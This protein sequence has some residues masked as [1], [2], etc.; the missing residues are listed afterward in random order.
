MSLDFELYVEVDTG[1][2]EFYSIDLFQKNITHNLNKMAKEAD[3]YKWLWGL[4][5]NICAGALIKPLAEGLYKLKSDP[6]RFKK[7]EPS[8]GWGTYE[9]FYAS[10]SQIYDA[11]LKHPKALIKIYK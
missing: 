3:L 5:N 1:D 9:G 10:V 11:C 8:N 6:D 7:L 2:T 4:D